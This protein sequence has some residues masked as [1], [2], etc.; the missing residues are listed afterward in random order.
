M[1]KNRVT[2]G[3]GVFFIVLF[4][5]RCG[6]SVLGELVVARLT[7]LGD[8]EQYQRSAFTVL[9]LTESFSVS[10]FF[11]L[12]RVYS[13]AITESLGALFHIISFGNPILIDIGF[14]TIAF[15]G[16]FKFLMAVEGTTRRYLA[17]LMLSPSFNIWSSVAAKEA[18]IVF[19]VGTICAYLIRL[20][21][22]RMKIGALEILCAIGIFVFKVHYVP[23]LLAIYLFIVVGKQVKQKAALV[24]GAGLFSLVPLYLLRD[25]VDAMAFGIAPHF[26]GYGSTREAYW[27]EKYDVFFKAPYGMFQ[28]FFGTTL[29]ESASGPLQMASFLESAIIVGALLLIFLRGVHKLPVFSFFAGIS[30]LGWLLFAS[31]PLGIL[32]AGSA[33]RYRT[34]HMLLVFFIF[35]IMFSRDY[36]VLWRSGTGERDRDATVAPQVTSGT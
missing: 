9:E 32:N 23:A 6:M 2:V 11:I 17:L 21:E 18:L 27:I 1:N 26:L 35:A 22:N 20:Y 10:Q 5:Y 30:S 13:T 34:G 8:S 15:V 16:I 31:Y 24:V 25:K 7:S 12:S 36:F 14:Q 29:E 3:W 28:G 33:V 4:V 19:F